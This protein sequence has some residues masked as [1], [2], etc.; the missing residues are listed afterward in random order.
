MTSR[1]TRDKKRY[2]IYPKRSNKK[3]YE[4]YVNHALQRRSY[5]NAMHKPTDLIPKT[6]DTTRL[7]CLECFSAAGHNSIKKNK[8]KEK[9]RQNDEHKE[10]QFFVLLL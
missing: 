4:F 2:T 7:C 10:R 8:K 6:T 9:T 5:S 3:N 1:K